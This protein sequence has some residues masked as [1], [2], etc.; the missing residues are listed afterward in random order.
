MP[1]CP[2]PSHL[3]RVTA[4]FLLCLPA[5]AALVNR[6]EA[7]DGAITYTDQSCSEDE[8]FSQQQAYHPPL[9]S[10]N[11][12]LPGREPAPERQRSAGVPVVVVKDSG[13]S[14]PKKNPEPAVKKTASQPKRYNA[15]E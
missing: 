13:Q 7:P 8:R 1:T 14:A 5:H 15:N 9:G 10:S 6:C 2:F 12:L 4:T 11:H 3:A